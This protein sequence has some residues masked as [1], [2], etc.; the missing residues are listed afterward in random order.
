MEPER[1]TLVRAISSSVRLSKRLGVRARKEEAGINFD[2]IHLPDNGQVFLKPK[3][4]LLIAEWYNNPKK[5][6]QQAISY[7]QK[8][9]EMFAEWR[10]RDAA[11]YYR[12]SGDIVE[13]MTAYL[14][15][16]VALMM[17]SELRKAVKMFETGCALAQ[18]KKV[19]DVETAFR[20]NLGQAYCDLGKSEC[21]QKELEEAVNLS[22][23]IGEDQLEL[24]SLVR[25]GL[26]YFLRGKYDRGIQQ[27]RY[28]EEKAWERKDLAFLADVLFC[29]GVLLMA[30][31][32]FKSAEERLLRGINYSEN[33]DHSY[34]TIR[35]LT[36]QTSL[37]L[38]L[39]KEE[40]AKEIAERALFLCRKFSHPQGEARC[41]EL[42]AEIYLSSGDIARGLEFFER[43]VEINRQTEYRHGMV[44]A[45]LAW[46]RMQLRQ[47][48]FEKS[49]SLAETAHELA[50]QT[51]HRSLFLE[52]ATLSVMLSTDWG[53]MEKVF[54][55][56]QLLEKSILAKLPGME[57][58]ILKNLGS[59]SMATEQ[60]DTAME[61]F[62]VALDRCQEIDSR[63]E[64]GKVYELMSH[65]MQQK[66]EKEL[67]VEYMGIA[68]SLCRDI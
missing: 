38:L 60:R 67:A 50:N 54:R 42:L 49:R 9:E 10:Y 59:V 48:Q 61:Y 52:S 55:L 20:I 7:Y 4:E 39:G 28:A 8:G 19:V 56:E 11:D 34:I 64:K 47:G 14:A 21:A 41:S 36:Q 27:C 18:K 40:K 45:S 68:E 30:K 46:A 15:G 3:V 5:K 16:G 26:F 25:M 17:V 43:A 62:Q 32:R 13:S 65:L 63:F 51:G 24:L 57:I 12:A 2:R 44:R 35:L 6:E 33:I 58:L 66:G 1:R 53:E 22:R 37:L 31:G 29:Q 23:Q